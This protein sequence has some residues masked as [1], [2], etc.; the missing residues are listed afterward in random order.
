VPERLRELAAPC[1]KSS[2]L[3]PFCRAM[4]GRTAPRLISRPPS[5]RRCESRHARLPD[6]W[7]R[8]L[9]AILLGDV[10]FHHRRLWRSVSCFHSILRLPL[11]IRRL[12]LG[13]SGVGDSA[14]FARPHSRNPQ[15]WQVI[16]PSFSR[17]I[18]KLPHAGQARRFPVT[19]AAFRASCSHPYTWCLAIPALVSK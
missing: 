8:S 7:V 9:H 16:F 11:T 1:E 12:V 5:A 3:T 17:Y 14:Q 13:V 18:A 2:E 19:S 15:V 4:G 10:C 6:S